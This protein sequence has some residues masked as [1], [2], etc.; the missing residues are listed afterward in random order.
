MPKTKIKRAS[1]DDLEA[2]VTV[3]QQTFSETFA[4]HNTEADMRLYLS[5]NMSAGNLK[6]E[7]ENE[8]SEFYFALVDD[9]NNPGQV[10]LTPWTVYTI[11]SV[12]VPYRY[13][14]FQNGAPDTLRIQYYVGNKITKQPNSGWSSGAS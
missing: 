7:L 4:A 12:A 13:F 6:A 5:R 14:R 9:P 1:L 2:L 8:S 11:D 10:P 3:S